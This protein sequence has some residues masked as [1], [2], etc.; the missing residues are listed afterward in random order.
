MQKTRGF[1]HKEISPNGDSNSSHHLRLK[2]VEVGDFLLKHVKMQKHRVYQK[3]GASILFFIKFFVNF[4]CF[5]KFLIV[6]GHM[7]I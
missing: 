5:I 4:F 3:L 2:V 7:I 6:I 1:L